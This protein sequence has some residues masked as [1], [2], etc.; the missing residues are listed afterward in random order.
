ML[1]A[2][3]CSSGKA[4]PTFIS[5]HFLTILSLFPGSLQRSLFSFPLP[6]LHHDPPDTVRRAGIGHLRPM[7]HSTSTSTGTGSDPAQRLQ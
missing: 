2:A 1:K 3:D 4:R 5:A 7:I 6:R